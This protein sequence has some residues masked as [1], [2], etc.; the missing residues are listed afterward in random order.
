MP[1]DT[2]EKS[3]R[4]LFSDYGRVRSV[5]LA[6]DI[7]T[8]RCKGFCSVEM[9]GHEARAALA[10]LDGRTLPDG[11]FFCKRSICGH[12]PARYAQLYF[13]HEDLTMTMLE[14]NLSEAVRRVISPEEANNLLKQLSSW[15][16]ASTRQWKARANAHQNALDSGDP[17]EYAKVLKGLA[18]IGSEG[19][20]HTSDRKHFNRSLYLLTE[21]LACA[22]KKTP[23]QVSK[24]IAQAVGVTL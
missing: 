4:D 10:V 14:E 23:R 7:F 22:L 12:A 17:F 19:P 6:T 24:L 18:Q 3:S 16:G 21:E 13:E 9:E 11:G 5:D 15:D 8:G 20:L 2:T 1:L